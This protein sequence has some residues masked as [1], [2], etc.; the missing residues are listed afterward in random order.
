MFKITRKKYVLGLA[1]I[2]I[3]PMALLGQNRNAPMT[4]WWEPSNDLPNPWVGQL[5]SLPDDRTWGS[6]AGVDMDPTDGS[7]WVI[8][9]CGSNT[10]VGANLDPILHYDASGR[11]LSSFGSNMFA[12]PHGIHVDLNGNVWVTDP[13]PADGRGAGGNVGQ[14]VTKFNADGEVLMELGT[15]CLLVQP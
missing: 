1:V 5:L 14:Q 6:T 10:C 11:F 4:R 15:K 13:L 2:L 8:D 9:R 7:V 12:F 3:W